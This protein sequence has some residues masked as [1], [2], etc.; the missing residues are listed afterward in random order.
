MIPL[1]N[2]LFWSL[3]KLPF[4]IS[5][6]YHIGLTLLYKTVVKSVLYKHRAVKVECEV[7]G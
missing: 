4:Y 1:D 2:L 5:N 7:R 6:D 3:I